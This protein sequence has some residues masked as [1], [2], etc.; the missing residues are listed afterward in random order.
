MGA[1]ITSRLENNDGSADKNVKVMVKSDLYVFDVKAGISLPFEWAR[2]G[3]AGG[4]VDGNVIVA[5]GNNWSK[6]K[7]T[8]Y[9][10][11]N[12]AVFKNGKWVAGP[13][14]P[15]PVAYAMYGYDKKGFYVAGGTSDGATSLKDAY[16]IRSLAEGNAWEKLPDLKEGLANGAGAVLKGKFYISC[17]TIG[18]ERTNRMWMLDIAKSGTEWVECKSVPGAGRMFPSLV[19]SGKYLYLLG[20]LSEVSPLTPLNDVYRYDPLKD[21]WTRLKDLPLKGYAWVSQSLDD[22]NILVTGRADGSIHRGIYVVNLEDMSVKEAGEL[23]LPSTTAPL[24]PV[25]K[26]EWWLVGGEPDANKN[27]TGKISVI[28]LK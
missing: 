13:E 21:E 23:T 16:A 2:G 7:I 25:G 5:G 26:K 1:S 6:D 4:V 27:R 11:K 9:W 3:H 19:A 24:I 10:L 20:G 14:F 15:N 8:K 28:T 18:T 22:K 17:G 12:S